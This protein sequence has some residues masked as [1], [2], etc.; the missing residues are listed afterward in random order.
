MEQR[1]RIGSKQVIEIALNVG[2]ATSTKLP[3]PTLIFAVVTAVARLMDHA[4][5]TPRRQRLSLRARAPR[6]NH[7]LRTIL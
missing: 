7:Q 2:R 4:G 5:D 3:T 1:C 6:R